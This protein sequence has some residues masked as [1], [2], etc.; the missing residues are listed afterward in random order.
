MTLVS[1]ELVKKFVV[2]IK[3]VAVVVIKVVA[4]VVIKVVAVAVILIISDLR[5]SEEHCE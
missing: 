3:V 4:V 5:V 1:G 2:V